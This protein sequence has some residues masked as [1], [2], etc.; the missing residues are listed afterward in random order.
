[1][2]LKIT[3]KIILCISLFGIGMTG[4]GGVA[5]ADGWDPRFSATNIGSIEQTRHNLTL[6]YNNSPNASVMNSFRNNYGETCVY[7]HTPHGANRQINAPLWNR[8]IN[9]VDNYSIYDSPTTLGLEGRLNLPGPSSLTC[10]SCHDGTIAIDSV[11][12]MPGSGLAPGSNLRNLEVGSPNGAFLDSWAAANSN[13]MGPTGSHFA[14]GP[15]PGTGESIGGCSVCHQLS[16]D[17]VDFAPDF[18]A[19][20]L[21]TNLRNDHVVGITYPTTFGPGIDYNEPEVTVLGKWSFF[22]SNGN[23]FAEKDEVR[24]YDSGNGP[25]VECASCHDP[26]GIPS[27]NGAV[28]EFIPSFLRISNSTPNNEGIGGP[29]GL[30]LTC[31]AK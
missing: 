12:N 6:S 24:L 25:A 18:S 2:S 7:C 5:F 14:L 27:N 28:S 8:T 26:H 13:N 19:F 29:S 21:G 9:N 10:L 17:I 31:H 16:S 4:I 23:R 30:C 22:D 1:M 3:P 11:L 15:E 20:I